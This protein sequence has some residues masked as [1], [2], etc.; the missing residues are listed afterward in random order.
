S[1]TRWSDGPRCCVPT[2]PSPTLSA[3][4]TLKAPGG[5]CASICASSTGTLRRGFPTHTN[6]LSSG[7]TSPLR[8]LL[9]RLGATCRA[10]A[11][12]AG[13]GTPTGSSAPT[14]GRNNH[15]RLDLGVNTRPAAA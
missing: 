7:A 15:E 12:N 1:A 3:Q 2:P 11:N 13:K 5:P 14:L 4:K 8:E 6:G 10:E 9:S